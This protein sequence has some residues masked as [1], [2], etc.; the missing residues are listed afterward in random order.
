MKTIKY[1]LFILVIIGLVSCASSNQ[2]AGSD[3]ASAG[4]NMLLV[5]GDGIQKTYTREDLEAFPLSQAMFND[6][7]YLGVPVSV[8]L[9]DAG[10]DPQQVKAV[11]AVASDGYTIN[12]DP[13]QFMAEGFMVAYAAVDGDL[14]AE[15]GVFRIVFPGAEG[16]LNLRMLV[17][18][19][20]IR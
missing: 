15:D 14:S 8:L 7:T 13:S 10:V 4:E 11:K 16:K 9:K 1:F 20:I 5:S 3:A 19:K 2:P 12:Y 17:E 6:I 18:L